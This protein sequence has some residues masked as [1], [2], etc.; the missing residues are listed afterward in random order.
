M[1]SDSVCAEGLARDSVEIIVN[2]LLEPS[3]EIVVND[4]V[5]CEL[6]EFVFDT[7]SSC[8]L[9]TSPSPRDA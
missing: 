8:L 5:Q 1:R 7:L 4:A 9:Y 3:I 2:P 6:E